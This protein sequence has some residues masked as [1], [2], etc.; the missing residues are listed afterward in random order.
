M[1]DSTLSSPNFAT[2]RTSR[3]AFLAQ[4]AGSI[5][6]VVG[7][8]ALLDAC[9]SASGTASKGT[10]PLTIMYFSG[11]ITKDQVAVFQKANPDLAVTYLDYDPTRLNAMYAAGSPPDLVR[12]ADSNTIVSLAARG[13][14]LPIDSY[15]AK[16]SVI[17]ESN[18]AP[19]NDVYR[20]DGKTQGQGARYGFVKD[21]S[22]DLC[23]WYNKKL[24]DQAHLSYPSATTP[25]T[26][27]EFLDLG[28]RLTQRD[29]DKIKVYGLNPNWNIRFAIHGHIMQMMAQRG[30]KLFSADLSTVDF[31]Q[32]DARAALQWYVDWGTAHIGP[33]PQEPDVSWDGPLFQQDRVAMTLWGYFYQGAAIAGNPIS[34]HVGMAPAPQFGSTRTSWCVSGT[35]F[36]IPKA[37][38]NPDGAWRFAEWFGAGSDATDR[39][40]AGSGLPALKSNYALLPQETDTQKE[41]YQVQQAELQYFGVPHYS[42]YISSDAMQTAI[43]KYIE[44]VMLGKSTL[45]AAIPQLN[46]AINLLLQQGKSQIS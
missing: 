28:K 11:E 40:K 31:T 33:G 36:Y 17:K 21:W 1:A 44:P 30:S 9:G 41:S 23:F 42:P 35:G 32:P 6:A 22:S 34:D 24:F 39:A 37:A 45:D 19:V 3:R 46:S 5:G 14:A 16:S 25:L 29:G 7:L 10:T 43:A 4:S 12:V 2:R 18:L 15:L 38:K 20:W 27:A 8:G 13:L 26:Y